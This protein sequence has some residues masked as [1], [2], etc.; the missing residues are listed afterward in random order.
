[1]PR[2]PPL[3]ILRD[4]LCDARGVSLALLRTD[5]I[6]PVISGN[7][8][9]KLKYNLAEA[10]RRGH[11]TLLSFGGAYSNHLHALAGAGAEYGFKTLG[12]IRGEEHLPLNRTLSFARDRGMRLTYLDRASYR[13][14]HAPEILARLIEEFGDFYLIPEGGGNALAVQGCMEMVE[15]I[16]QPFDVLA[17][18]CGTGATLAGLA[19]GLNGAQQALGFAVLKGA[20]FLTRE[21]QGFLAAAGHGGLA[22]WSINLDYHFGGYAKTTPALIDFI[23]RFEAEHAIPLEQVYT[24]KLLFGLYDLIMKGHFAPGTRLIAVHSGGLQ[25]RATGIP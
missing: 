6:H 25:G 12:V 17:C 3:Q 19:A 23:A 22:N 9:Y 20:G 15:A 7:K 24:G 14:K 1:M 21:V 16:G 8:W 11:D 18:A 13:R 5:L 2:T 4:P 10:R